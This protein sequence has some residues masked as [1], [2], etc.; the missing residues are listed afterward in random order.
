MRYDVPGNTSCN[1]KELI[2]LIAK[3][4]QVAFATEFTNYKKIY[5]GSQ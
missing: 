1:Q 3:E 4:D 2:E 5:T